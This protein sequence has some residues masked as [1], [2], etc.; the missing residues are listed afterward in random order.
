MKKRKRKYLSAE[1][2]AR[3]EESLNEALQH[4]RGERHDL[5]KTVRE[6]PVKKT[7]INICLDED[8]IEHFRARAARP[9]AAPYQTQINQA[10]RDH[11]SP[12]DH[13]TLTQQTEA[14]ADLIA[15]KIARRLKPG[16]KAA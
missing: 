1:D 11:L 12:D 15:E 16:R 8:I 14:L 13:S 5:R 3:L 4:A 9:N 2:F 6:R 10:L 7:R